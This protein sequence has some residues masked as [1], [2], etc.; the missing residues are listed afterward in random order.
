MPV[1]VPFYAAILG[2]IFIFLSARVI[3]ARRQFRV[4]VG[5]GGH[6]LLERRIRVQGNFSEYVPIT[7]ILLTFLELYGGAKWLI[8]MLCI[9][10][11]LGRSLH[12]YCVSRTDEDIRQRRAAMILTFGALLVAAIGVAIYSGRQMFG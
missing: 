5:F 2:L 4:T 7:I 12:A 11:I 6:H 9:A 10:L 1:I 8:H 3:A